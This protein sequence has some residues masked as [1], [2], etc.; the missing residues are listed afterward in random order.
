MRRGVDGEGELPHLASRP[1]A[2]PDKHGHGHEGEGSEL[3]DGSNCDVAGDLIC[4]TPADPGPDWAVAA[5]CAEQTCATTCP[6]DANAATYTPDT[7][8][9]MSW[10]LGSSG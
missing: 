3:V 1:R 8:N 4:E 10:Y 6:T 5:G 2:S 9:I 7:T